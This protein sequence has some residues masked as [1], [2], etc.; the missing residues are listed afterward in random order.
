MA[1]DKRTPPIK[2]NMLEYEIADLE[3]PNDLNSNQYGGHRVVF[4]INVADE[5]KF[6]SGTG[7]TKDVYDIPAGE[8]TATAG[9]RTAAKTK[10]ILGEAEKLAKQANINIELKPT[11]FTKRLKAAISLYVPND[12]SFNYTT[13]WGEEDLS[14]SENIADTFNRIVDSNSIAR[15]VGS[16]A[17]GVLRSKMGQ[18]RSNSAIVN[19]T[20]Q[21]PGNAKAEQLFQGVDFRSFNFS[22]DFAPRSE[23]EAIN[24]MNIISMFKHHMLPEFKDNDQFLFI[25]PSQFEIKYFKGD[26]ENEFLDKHFT[27]I[28]TNCSVN[29]TA[30]GQFSTFANGMPTHIR[31]TLGFKELSIPT[32]ET[33]P[34]MFGQKAYKDQI[35]INRVRGGA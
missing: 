12:L 4:L 1:E 8:L 17:T 27:A 34:A 7:D 26:K 20:Q 14:K 2:Y 6:R 13:S 21:T 28:C 23:A 5:S 30:N 3:Y 22:Y 25:F 24:V 18:I 9:Q 35:K 11:S 15:G 31:M 32:K 29:Y 10:E 33:T 16:L 19:A